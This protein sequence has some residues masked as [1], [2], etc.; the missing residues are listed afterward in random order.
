MSIAFTI[1]SAAADVLL[2]YMIRRLH[3]MMRKQLN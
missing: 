3:R 1:I 2:I